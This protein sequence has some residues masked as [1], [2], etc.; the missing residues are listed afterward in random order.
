[1]PV[2]V[3]PLMSLWSQEEESSE[4]TDSEMAKLDSALSAVF[5]NAVSNKS[6]RAAD[7]ERAAQLKTFK[8]RRVF[9]TKDQ[10]QLNLVVF[11]ILLPQ[12][13]MCL[14]KWK[15]ITFSRRQIIWNRL[16]RIRQWKLPAFR[17]LD[18]VTILVQS[19]PSLSL[20]L[21]SV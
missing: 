4:M 1:M 19:H 18:L 11:S 17:C 9:L 16:I 14:Q 15:Q 7:K 2:E 20:L 6:N 13:I 3:V 12:N 21:V 8:M 10:L 5:R